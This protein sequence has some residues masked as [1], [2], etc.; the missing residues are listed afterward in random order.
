VVPYHEEH[1]P[2]SSVSVAIRTDDVL[3]AREPLH[4]VSAR[5]VIAGTVERIVTHGAEAEVMVRTGGLSWIVSVVTPAVAALDLA[6]GARV[7][8][9]IKARSCQILGDDPDRA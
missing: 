5:N 6:S 3:L 9:V 4:G 7:S 2:G 8:L 1:P